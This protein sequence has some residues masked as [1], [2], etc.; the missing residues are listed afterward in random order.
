MQTSTMQ[1]HHDGA[2]LTPQLVMEKYRRAYK[3]VHGRE[4]RVAHV[5]A[6]WYQVNGEMVHRVTLF[7][8]I[9]RLRDLAKRQRI[10]NTDRSIIQRL[11]AKLRAS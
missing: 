2:T 1:H 9:T 6:E 11:I 5:F 7:G 3:L 4:P 8:E 10:N